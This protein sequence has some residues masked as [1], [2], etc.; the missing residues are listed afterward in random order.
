MTSAYEYLKDRMPFQ[1]RDCFFPSVRHNHRFVKFIKKFWSFEFHTIWKAQH[2]FI[3]SWVQPCWISE[4]ACNSWLAILWTHRA[5]AEW[6]IMHF[7]TNGCLNVCFFYRKNITT[8][9]RTDLWRPKEGSIP[10]RLSLFMMTGHHWAMVNY[11]HQ[12]LSNVLVTWLDLSV[13][14]KDRRGFGQYSGLVHD[15]VVEMTNINE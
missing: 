12:A 8:A 11:P 1:N 2:G 4:C 6:C 5:N 3:H 15:P 7:G 13:L 9:I 14:L 10:Q